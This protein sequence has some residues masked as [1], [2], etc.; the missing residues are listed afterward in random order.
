MLAGHRKPLFRKAERLAVMIL[1]KGRGLRQKPV[2]D[3]G[4]GSFLSFIKLQSDLKKGDVKE[5]DFSS[6]APRIYEIIL[7][8][9]VAAGKKKP[10]DIDLMVLDNGH[11]SNFFPCTTKERHTENWYEDLGDNLLWLMNGWFEVQEEQLQEILGDTKV[12]L[13]IL[14]LRLLK[15]P[16]FRTEAAEKHKDPDFFRNAFGTALRLNRTTR[17]FEPLTLEYLE[18]RYCCNLV[19]LRSCT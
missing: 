4:F 12:D 11:F 1:Q 13:H 3:L 19:D 16:D 2:K 8:G 14:P 5:E 10:T 9:S 18:K 15:S 7:F 6:L 17:K